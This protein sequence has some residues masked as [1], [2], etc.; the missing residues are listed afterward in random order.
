MAAEG[1]LSAMEWQ[2]EFSADNWNPEEW[3]NVKSPRWAHFGSWEQLDGRI[4]NQVPDDATAEEML[5]PRAPETYSSMLWKQLLKGPV[6]ISSRMAFADR[7]APLLVISP[8]PEKNQ[9]G[10]PEYREHWEIVLFD[11]GL[12]VWHHQYQ[13]GK[14]SWH[15]AAYARGKFRPDT[16]YDLQLQIIPRGD[17]QEMRVRCQDIEFGFSTTALPEEFLA[18]ITG[19]E[20]INYFYDFRVQAPEQ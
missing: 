4:T 18:G 11:E 14:P 16:V 8:S 9:D 7:M 5:G 10:I 17:R 3:F 13:D 6:T 2:C 20:G 12:N 1:V 19:C 15:L